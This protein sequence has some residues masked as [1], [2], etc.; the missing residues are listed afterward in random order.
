MKYYTHRF[1]SVRAH[2]R[3][4]E[5]THGLKNVKSIIL[6]PYISCEVFRIFFYGKLSKIRTEH[7]NKVSKNVLKKLYIY[8]YIYKLLLFFYC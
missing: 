2:E 8:I 6:L 3:E 7:N 4:R 1:V 5:R